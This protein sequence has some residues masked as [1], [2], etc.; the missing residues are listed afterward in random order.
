MESMAQ[1]LARA[2]RHHQTG[3]LNQAEQDY[4]QVLRADPNCAHASHGLGGIAFDRRQYPQAIAWHRQAVAL[5]GASAAMHND[6]GAAY[7][8]AAQPAE[9]EACFRQALRLR[10]DLAEVYCNLGNVLKMQG[11]LQEAVARYHLAVLARP[12]YVEAHL[13]LG[14]ALREQGRHHEALAQLQQ[15]VRIRPDH[16]EAHGVLGSV[17]REQGRLDEALIRFHQAHRLKPD[18][19]KHHF[20]L[21]EALQEQ[22]HWEEAVIHLREA[23]RVQPRF[24]KTH[25]LLGRALT[26]LDRLE[27]AVAFLQQAL[28][29]QPSLPGLHTDLGEAF[30]RQGLLDAALAH[31]LAEPSQT[32][33]VGEHP[34]APPTDQKSPEPSEPVTQHP[35][36][37]PDKPGPVEDR[38][39]SGI[40][41][42]K[43]GRL[44]E[45]V[46]VFEE[47]LTHTPDHAQTRYELGVTCTA[48]NE[49]DQAIAHYREAVHLDPELAE[50]HVALGVALGERGNLQEAMTAFHHALRIEPACLEALLNLGKAWRDRGDR[51]RSVAY[52]RYALRLRP[53]LVEGHY[54]LG[55]TLAEQGKADEAVA[56]YREALRL[57]P[58][59]AST[60][61]QLG[62]LS[63]QLGQLEEGRRLLKQ[64]LDVAPDDVEAHVQYGQALTNLGRPE[65][66]TAHFL[67][68][69]A[70]QPAHAQAY[71]FLARDGN[72]QFTDAEIGRIKDLLNR[73]RVP[74]GDRIN[75]HFAL[76]RVLDRAKAFD[77]AFQHCDQGNA[78]KRE[79]LRRQGNGFQ[80]DVHARFVDRLRATFDKAFFQRVGSFGTDSDLPVFVVGM[81]RSGST[82]VEQMLASHPAVFGAGEIGN[83]SQ[84]VA[85]L[86]AELAST[87]PFPECLT[88]LDQAASRRLAEGYIERLGRLAGGKLRVTDKMLT[89]TYHL[90]LIATLL[91]R[92]QVIHCRR[93]PRDVCWSCYFQNFADL[94]YT[95]DLRALGTYYRHYELLMAHWKA[96]LPLPV[97]K[98]CYEELVEDPERI[99]RELIAFCRLPWL[100][101]C[102]RFSETRR[103]V[104]TLSDIQ[105]RQPI[106]KRAVGYWK[107][108]E[109]H[110][111]PLLEALN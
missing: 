64:A 62:V 97:Y 92:S 93:D 98:L 44:D 28:R 32:A 11:Q 66:A 75:L 21:G 47:A 90:G 29:L 58:D 71:F 12:N 69:L 67:Q 39:A 83:V 17:L 87:A 78:C 53:D 108:Y 85:E 105:V 13:M 41:L 54:K 48:K 1:A 38:L 79:L 60:L 20:R 65:E 19:V 77:E 45:A 91:P 50:A 7:L 111:G 107:N 22:G 89:N 33:R 40:R 31:F 103:S 9:A 34:A 15:A 96:V 61:S 55:L 109:R 102:L 84:F 27:E 57:K 49:R 86:P 80:P 72:H 101:A 59:S 94:P 14:L 88:S 26:K 6:L 35:Q 37:P 52:L 51:E 81:P 2:V 68:A 95:C 3:N 42:R 100:D 36:V 99:G 8:A 24:A 63:L 16:P 43:Q 25:Y 104:R 73:D 4:N 5:P 76:A 70:L 110:L 18:D 106:S 23:V 82:L 46:A 56:A 30:Q 74:L 10:P